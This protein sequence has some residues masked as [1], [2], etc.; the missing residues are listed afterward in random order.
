M[1]TPLISVC[2]P[3]LNTFPFLEERVE[4]ILGQTCADWELIVIDSYSDDGSWEHFQKLAQTDSR[5]SISQAPRGL[6]QCWNAC[7]ERA[8][9]KYVYF[10]T[11]DDTMAPDCLEKLASALEEHV[12]C[13][14][15]ACP[16]TAIGGDGKPLEDRAWWEAT[17]FAHWN[18]ELLQQ[19]HMRRA[20]FDGLLHLTGYMV[21]LSITQMMIRRSLFSRIGGFET[22]WDSIGDRNWEMK[23]GL[24]AN[25]I[26]VPDTWAT[27]R[28]HPANATSAM[29]YCSPDYMRKIEEMLVDA[30]GKCESFLPAQVLAGLKDSW[31]ESSREMRAYYGALRNL[32][33]T[34]KRLFQLE[35][36]CASGNSARLEV[37]RRL[38]GKPKWANRAPGELRDWLASLGLD[39][40]VPC[41][42]LKAA[43]NGQNY[44]LAQASR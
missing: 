12:D 40:I 34:R 18:S 25:T 26:H 28:I 24:V 14:I 42:G 33:G 20:P 43:S 37:L 10:A 21:H 31:L 2:L 1:K 15:A 30:V 11:S 6:Y 19:R 7:I 17:V 13:D 16:L 9:G 27:W 41:V 38:Q 23:A 36:L 22:R 5:V 4:T 32:R 8:Q 44:S 3:S 39:P 35:Q 29:V